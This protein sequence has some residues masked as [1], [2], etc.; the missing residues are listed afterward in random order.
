M[1]AATSFACG[2]QPA[3]VAVA[4]FEALAANDVEGALARVSDGYSD[5]LGK[6]AELARDLEDLV[7]STGRIRLALS[8]ISTVPGD[9]KLEARVIGRLDVEL[10][11]EPAWR[12]TG[13]LELDLRRDDGFRIV[14]GFLAELRGIRRL[15]ADRRAALESNDAALYAKLLHPTYRDGENDREVAEERLTRDLSGGVRIRLEPSLYK[16]ELRGPTAHLDE[17]YRL[18][19]GDRVLPPSIARLTLRPAAGLWRIAAGLY[20]EPSE[21]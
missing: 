10:A 7:N 18:T 17:H 21:P 13:P 1:L 11:G 19:V 12:V 9:S 8:E 5:P 3:E 6:K 2:P 16:L 20:P 4:A 14:G 15:M